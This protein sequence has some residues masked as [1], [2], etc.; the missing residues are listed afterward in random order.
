MGGKHRAAWLIRGSLAFL[1]ARCTRRLAG[2]SVGIGIAACGGGVKFE[3]RS[4]PSNSC[5]YVVPLVKWQQGGRAAMLN[6]VRL[7]D[8]KYCA[9]PKRISAR[10]YTYVLVVDCPGGRQFEEI[11]PSM[12]GS[13]GFEYT[14]R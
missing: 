5:F 11:R 10:D 9:T 1:L 13:N 12:S 14:C 2:L 4:N 6:S 8:Y 3:V 7:E